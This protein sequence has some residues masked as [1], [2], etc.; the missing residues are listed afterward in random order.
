MH[1]SKMESGSSE[2]T[3]GTFGT[4]QVNIM[5]RFDLEQQ[6][7]ECWNIVD[8]LKILTEATIEKDLD[9]D[10]IT[11]ITIGLEKLYHL[12]F[13]KLFDTFEALVAN[14]RLQHDSFPKTGFG[15]NAQEEP[16]A[17]EFTLFP[18]SDEM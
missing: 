11:N 2:S 5:T 16:D 10:D 3:F 13:E 4:N 14:G 18:I 15:L 12:R 9:R 8:D 17:E 1:E 6:I 7:L